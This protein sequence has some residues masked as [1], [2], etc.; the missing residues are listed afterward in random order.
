M[1][2]ST[3]TI[4]TICHSFLGKKLHTLPRHILHIPP[5]I[6]RQWIKVYVCVYTYHE[7][8]QKKE[9]KFR[10]IKRML[11]SFSLERSKLK[12]WMDNPRK[13]PGKFQV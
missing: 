7:A 1:D 3:N 13:T 2:Y 6:S 9:D 10:K 8:I 4:G 12:G 5:L 11:I